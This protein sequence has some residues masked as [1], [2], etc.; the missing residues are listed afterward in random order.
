MNRA[1][2][3][4]MSTICER[5]EILIND[6]EWPSGSSVV[7][8]RETRHP[9]GESQIFLLVGRSNSLSR[10]ALVESPSAIIHSFGLIQT[11]SCTH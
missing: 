2:C 11:V 5:D 10:L 3:G 9:V 4:D 8:I 1:V 6:R 7:W